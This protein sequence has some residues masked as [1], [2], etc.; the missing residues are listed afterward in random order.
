M[1]GGGGHSFWATAGGGGDGGGGDAGTTGV[2][3]FSHVSQV[4][5]MT[6]GGGGGEE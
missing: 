5:H 6:E 2:H 4:V 3:G 1:S